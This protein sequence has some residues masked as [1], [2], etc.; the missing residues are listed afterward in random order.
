MKKYAVYTGTRNLYHDMEV[1]SKSLIAN[2]NVD[3]VYFLIEDDVFPSKLPE[4]IIECRNMSNQQFFNPTGPNMKNK[5]SYMAMIRIAFA[6]I[7]EDIPKILSLDCDTIVMKDISHLWD[8][9]LDE[10]YF[11]ASPEHDRSKYDL[12]YCNHGVVLYNLDR[13][14]QGKAKECIEILNISPHRFVDQDIGNFLC[15][16]RIHKMPSSYNMNRFTDIHPDT[17]NA[18]IIHYAGLKQESWHNKPEVVYWRNLDWNTVM[19]MHTEK[20]VRYS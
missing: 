18:H 2:S 9:P 17:L 14:R 4:N 3:K 15:Q 7:F 19:S 12:V 16:G 5:F 13:M 1:A 8:I 20:V 11:S 10:Y 6:H